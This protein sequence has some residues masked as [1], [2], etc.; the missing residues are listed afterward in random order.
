MSQASAGPAHSL[1]SGLGGC[2][3]R[4]L[5]AAIAVHRAF[6]LIMG[7]VTTLVLTCHSTGQFNAD[8]VA[9][10]PRSPQTLASNTR[11]LSGRRDL[12]P[13]RADPC[14]CTPGHS[15][16]ELPPGARAR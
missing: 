10:A 6:L 11:R 1:M 15:G 7:G 2:R 12:P 5:V 14:C 4:L 13:H 8:L 3:A 16:D 9:A